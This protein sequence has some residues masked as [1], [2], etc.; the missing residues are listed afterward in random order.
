MRCEISSQHV[1]SLKGPEVPGMQRSK[2]GGQVKAVCRTVRGQRANTWGRLPPRAPCSTLKLQQV[3][4]RRPW[5]L[6]LGGKGGD[7]KCTLGTSF[8]FLLSCWRSN[9]FLPQKTAVSH[10]KT[11]QKEAILCAA[12]CGE[13]RS[14]PSSLPAGSTDL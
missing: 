9:L 12:V 14:L 10:V 4:T 5:T 8:L 13:G 6:Q 7:R 1:T 11:K 2:W 3:L